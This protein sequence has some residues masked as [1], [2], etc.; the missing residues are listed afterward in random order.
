[1]IHAKAIHYGLKPYKCDEC[2]YASGFKHCVKQHKKTNHGGEKDKKCPHCE[3]SAHVTGDLKTHMKRKHKD[4]PM[5]SE[6][7][8]NE[9]TSPNDSGIDAMEIDETS[10]DDKVKC[11]IC[12]LELAGETNLTKHILEKHIAS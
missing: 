11:Q 10:S 2:S 8:K 1:M 9:Q 7:P 3:Y 6:L 4:A 5:S 12:S